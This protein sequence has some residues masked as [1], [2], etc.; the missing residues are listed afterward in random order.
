[1]SAI[2][3]RLDPDYDVASPPSESV[4]MTSVA[5]SGWPYVRGGVRCQLVTNARVGTDC[6]H[7]VIAYQPTLITPVTMW[8][9]PATAFVH[10]RMLIAQNR[11]LIRRRKICRQL[12]Y[13]YHVF[14]YVLFE[15][16]RL[17]GAEKFC[18]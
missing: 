12:K 16:Q 15:F 8:K 9:W 14:S 5:M 11:I 1:M 10:L 6:D 7:Q 18:S 2:N 3:L 4:K 13:L 17:F